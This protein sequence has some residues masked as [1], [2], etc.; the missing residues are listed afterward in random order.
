VYDK[1]TKASAVTPHDTN[2]LSGYI[3]SGWD[4]IYIGVTGDVNM[5]LQDDTSAVVFK[6]MTQGTLYPIAAKTIKS[7]STDATD[8]VALESGG[9]YS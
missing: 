4:S 9:T 1:Y 6:N 8:I 3:G 5:I 7:T 2:E